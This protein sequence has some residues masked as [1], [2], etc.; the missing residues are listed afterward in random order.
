MPGGDAEEGRHSVM[1]DTDVDPEVALR[2][3]LATLKTEH[4]A[5]DD[6]IAA[7]LAA[8]FIDQLEVRRLK[9]R[10]LSLR[11]EIVRLEDMITP[12]IIA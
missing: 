8:P 2:A 10:K 1:A 9:K 6:W 5:L 7:L 12:D 3:R 11:D 4:R